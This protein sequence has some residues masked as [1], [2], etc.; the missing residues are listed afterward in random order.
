[1]QNEYMHT[2]PR[3]DWKTSLPAQHQV[4][5][6]SPLTKQSPVPYTN[7]LG[8]EGRAPVTIAEKAGSRGK[9]PAIC[10]EVEWIQ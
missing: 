7:K 1:M 5:L 8:I 4:L 2:I 3:S 10:Q 6:P 9:K